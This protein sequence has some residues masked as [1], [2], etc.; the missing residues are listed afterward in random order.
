MTL[1]MQYSQQF[2]THFQTASK[3]TPKTYANDQKHHHYMYADD[4]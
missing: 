4:D 2:Q 3:Q 1:L